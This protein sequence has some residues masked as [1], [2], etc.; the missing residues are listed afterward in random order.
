MEAKDR[1]PA[2]VLVDEKTKLSFAKGEE[3]LIECMSNIQISIDTNGELK[4]DCLLFCPPA[5]AS[6]LFK[7]ADI[8]VEFD[9]ESALSATGINFSNVSYR[10]TSDV[11]YLKGGIEYL[12]IVSK[13]Q[14]PDNVQVLSYF[15]LSPSVSLWPA[16]LRETFGGINTK[17][18][19]L[20]TENPGCAGILEICGN[21]LAGSL[22][23]PDKLIRHFEILLGL[24]TTCTVW[25]CGISRINSDGH[26]VAEYRS[27]P[28][29][30]CRRGFPII[31]NY[32]EAS[33]R[34]ELCYFLSQSVSALE[35]MKSKRY[36]A[37]REAVLFSIEAAYEV[38]I[39]PKYLKMFL[40]LIILLRAFSDPIEDGLLEKEEK[41]LDS[42]TETV[43]SADAIP[44]FKSRLVGALSGVRRPSER[45]R[46][47][48]L[49]EKY[50]LVRL[51]PSRITSR[52]RG[53]I[54]HAGIFR[55]D[56][57][58]DKKNV[59]QELSFGLSW[60][61][62]RILGYTGYFI[63]HKDDYKHEISVQTGETIEI[64]R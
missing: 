59:C 38:Y 64:V 16:A 40:S 1:L 8:R 5:E 47:V 31:P 52:I 21:D 30:R 45:E 57:L 13:E 26:L 63:H 2:S 14:N 15:L 55:G 12:K 41:L 3:T 33:E 32:C 6:R 22:A 48:R 56:E 62:L 23:E 34:E 24:A 46:I 11:Q 35:E 50:D 36:R 17:W 28:P 37:F 20:N 9:C 25:I 44:A 53:A 19:P 4:I 29:M 61:L 42:L 18:E 58:E 10:S 49:L 60:L 7:T 54:V 27:T 39:K 43:K 51:F